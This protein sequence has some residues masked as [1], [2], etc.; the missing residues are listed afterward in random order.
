MSVLGTIYPIDRCV[1]IMGAIQ[2]NRTK[3]MRFRTNLM[4]NFDVGARAE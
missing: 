1:L 3:V 4:I 2:A